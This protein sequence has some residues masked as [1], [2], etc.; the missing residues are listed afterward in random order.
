MTTAADYERLE[1]DLRD[2]A[3]TLS[4]LIA[5]E[6]KRQQDE[7]HRKEIEALKD[8]ALDERL[9]RNEARTNAIYSMGKWLATAAGSTLLLA[10]VTFI[11]KG[12]LFV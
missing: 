9:K 3:K 12:N 5:R 10:V 8:E 7:L 11:L 2:H 4:E 1:R 6:A